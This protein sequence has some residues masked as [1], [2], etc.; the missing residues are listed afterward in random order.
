MY[1]VTTSSTLSKYYSGHFRPGKTVL[2]RLIY[3]LVHIKLYQQK[4]TIHSQN[5]SE[6]Q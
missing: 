4:N 3:L 2:L 5:N 1:I 6:I